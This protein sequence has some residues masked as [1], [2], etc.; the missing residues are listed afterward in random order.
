MR[1]GAIYYISRA[2]ETRNL[3]NIH[4]EGRYIQQA[5]YAGRD[6][7]RQRMDNLRC[8]HLGLGILFKLEIM[9]VTER[10]Y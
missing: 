5:Y 3:V 2:T 10:K 9:R 4:D 8:G 6:L 7:N 1:G